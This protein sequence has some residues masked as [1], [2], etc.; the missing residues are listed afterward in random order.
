L[1]PTATYVLTYSLPLKKLCITGRDANR[2][3]WL[4]KKEVADA[5]AS[6]R[7]DLDREQKNVRELV[8]A[9][10]DWSPIV[11]GWAAEELAK[12]PEA[13]AMV[14][15]LIAMAEGKDVHVSQGACEALGCIKSEQAL[16]VLVRLLSHEDRWL[17]FK[18]AQALKKMGGAT[19]PAVPDIL[20][21]VVQ[22]A[23]PLQPI[24]W[25]DAIQLTHGQLAAALFA[26]PLTDAVKQS[27]PKL[28]YPAVRVVAT[29]ADGMARARLRGFFEN[30]LTVEDVQAL[31]PDL[32]AAVKTPSPADT[33]FSNEIRMGAYRAL[34]KVT[35]H[36]LEAIS[37]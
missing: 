1:S 26:G 5:V 37:W 17:R 10:G 27:D 35:L 11:R 12:R 2:S 32:L 14:P 7:F 9:F 21:A 15:Q 20:K 36:G 23:E 30:R 8:A 13:K 34:T 29:N 22:T 33:M 16:P 6:G 25:A 19:K 18:A 28:L 31:A 24:N 4:T 3:N